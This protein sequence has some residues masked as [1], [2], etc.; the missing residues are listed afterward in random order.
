M[1]IDLLVLEVSVSVPWGEID[2]TDVIVTLHSELTSSSMHPQSML[3]R[4]FF[5]LPSKFS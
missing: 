5:L 4:P 3:N 1:I 2:G